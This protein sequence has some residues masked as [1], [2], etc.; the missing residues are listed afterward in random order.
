MSN[1][2]L[3][4]MPESQL[5]EFAK[6]NAKTP[7]EKA[8][9]K[10]IT[11]PKIIT[12]QRELRARFWEKYPNLARRRGAAN[13]QTDEANQKFHYFLIDLLGKGIIGPGLQRR[14]TL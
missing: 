6:I 13:C 10:I 3:S 1:C 12:T 9:L 14:A 5:I 11:Q 7:L 2:I 8:L 4:F